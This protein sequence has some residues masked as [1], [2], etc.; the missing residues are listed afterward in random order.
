MIPSAH[1]AD[2]ACVIESVAIRELVDYTRSVDVRIRELQAEAGRKTSCGVS[3]RGS[4][5][6]AE[7]T[8]KIVDRAFIDTPI[9][10]STW[11][12]FEFNILLAKNSESRAP[13][14][15]DAQIFVQI[16]KKINAAITSITNQCN[17][18]DGVESGFILLL[19]QN[20]SLENIYKQAALGKPNT[21]P[22]G[23]TPENQK[24]AKAINDNYIPPKTAACKDQTGT[25]QAIDKLNKSIEKTGTKN[26]S[27]LKDWRIALAL[28]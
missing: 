3:S 28:L 2:Q 20:E 16:D 24:I 19:Q 6:A 5:A 7:R 10:D 25:A 1:A 9:F 4:I 27:A 13:V 11:L 14:T 12:D 26:E 21:S 18:E 15:R 22:I 23:F 17:L 8:A